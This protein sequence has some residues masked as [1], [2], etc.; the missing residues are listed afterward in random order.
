MAGW[1]LKGNANQGGFR[2]VTVLAAEAWEAAVA[3]LGTTVEQLPP[4]TRRANLLVRGLE[5]ADSRKRVLR[6]GAMRLMVLGETRPCRLMDESWSGLQ[7][8]LDPQWRG[9]VFG[10]VLE[11][12]RIALGDPVVWERGG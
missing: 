4:V 1:G 9:G 3:D 5:L 11:D 12:A 2:Q 8:A 10:Q 7:E 6:V